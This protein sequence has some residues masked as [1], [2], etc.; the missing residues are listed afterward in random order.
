[1]KGILR[2]HQPIVKYSNGDN[3]GDHSPGAEHETQER[4][5]AR[6]IGAAQPLQ[7]EHGQRAAKH[8]KGISVGRGRG[9]WRI[10]KEK[11]FRYGVGHGHLV[12]GAGILCARTSPPAVPKAHRTHATEI[13]KEKRQQRDS[14]S[15]CA[16][17]IFSIYPK[18]AHLGRQQRLDVGGGGS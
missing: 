2:S 15:V 7:P 13:E 18:V 4:A 8:A 6:G 11:S 10:S 12:L 3:R 9:C 5:R 14:K 16:H 1:M 17:K